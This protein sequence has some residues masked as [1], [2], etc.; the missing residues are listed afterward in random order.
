MSVL[1]D[2]NILGRYSQPAHE[3][4]ASCLAALSRL[5]RSG[6]E[7][8]TVPQVI[9]EFWVVA[10]RPDSQ[11][12]LGFSPEEAKRT[13]AAFAT[14]FPILRDERGIFEPWLELVTQL[15]CRGKAA[16]DARLVAA[17]QRHGLT[18]ILTFNSADFARY[19]GIRFLNPLTISTS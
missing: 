7:F 16:H 10:T 1:V 5:A 14:L 4:H 18:E 19:Q 9:Y 6:Y 13:V 12:G 15:P 3:Q 2:T 8:R 17:M 11:N